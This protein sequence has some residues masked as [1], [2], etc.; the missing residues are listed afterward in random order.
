MRKDNKKKICKRLDFCEKKYLRKDDI[1]IVRPLSEISLSLGE[2]VR[3]IRRKLMAQ[4]PKNKTIKWKLLL[5]FLK[6]LQ[7]H[8]Q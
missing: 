7:K 8:L 4:K 2:N 3:S 5:V 6:N 1:E